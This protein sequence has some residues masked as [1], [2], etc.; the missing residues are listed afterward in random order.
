MN[1]LPPINAVPL[2]P[3]E[4]AA[5]LEVLS[6]LALDDWSRDTACPGWSLKDIAAHLLA[7]DFGRLSSGPGP[8]RDSGFMP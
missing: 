7:D 5:L 2:F 3:E 6:S 1:P 8:H 4:R